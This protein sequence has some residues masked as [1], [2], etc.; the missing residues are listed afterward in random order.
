MCPL[1]HSNYPVDAWRNPNT[2]RLELQDGHHR[3][4]AGKKASLDK[5]PVNIGE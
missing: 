3:A 1:F 2:G 5:I 4:E